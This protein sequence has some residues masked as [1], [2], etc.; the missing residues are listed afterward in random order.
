MFQKNRTGVLK[1]YNNLRFAGSFVDKHWEEVIDRQTWREQL[2]SLESSNDQRTLGLCRWLWRWWG[3]GGGGTGGSESPASRVRS[4]ASRTFVPLCLPTPAL[5]CV[6]PVFRL[7]KTIRNPGLTFKLCQNLTFLFIFWS[8]F[9]RGDYWVPMKVVTGHDL[10]RN[11][12]E[13]IS[14][15]TGINAVFSALVQIYFLLLPN[16][17]LSIGGC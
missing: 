3:W 8:L 6:A 17:L 11:R 9:W 14:K 12:I 5:H 1:V 10:W 2:E 16:F 7:I 13:G 4:P 15:F